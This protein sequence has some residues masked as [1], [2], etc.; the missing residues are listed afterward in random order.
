MFKQIPPT[1]TTN[2]T[3]NNEENVQADLCRLELKR[4][5]LNNIVLI[6]GAQKGRALL[7]GS[8]ERNFGIG[9]L[10]LSCIMTH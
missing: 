9:K 8:T 5:N 7:H 4:V 10:E 2:N 1:S 6:Q 3:S